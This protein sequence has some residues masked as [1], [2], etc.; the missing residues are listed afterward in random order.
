MKNDGRA[1]MSAEVLSYSRGLTEF[2]RTGS[3]RA[4]DEREREPEGYVIRIDGVR[5]AFV[6]PHSSRVHAPQS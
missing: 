1:L 2:T 6:V 5:P 4:V 3:Y